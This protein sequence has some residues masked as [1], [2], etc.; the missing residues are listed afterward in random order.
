[1]VY[2][3][4]VA[5]VAAIVLAY[6]L[7]TQNK[8]SAKQA[9][10]QQR[11][12]DDYQQRVNEQQKLLEDYRALEK[13]FDNVGEGYEQALLA[14][15]KMNEE[16]DKARAANEALQNTVQQLQEANNQLQQDAQKKAEAMKQVVSDLMATGDQKLAALAGK[17]SDLDEIQPNQAP[18]ERT[19]NIMV[20]QVA[21]E[22][23]RQS[24]IDKAQYIKFNQ[25][26]DPTAAATM[27]STNLQKAARSLVHVLDNALKFTTEG[28]VTLAVT[29]DMDKMQAI[30][31]VEDTGSGIEADD[32]EKV[33]EPYVKLNQ[34]F[35]GQGIGLTVAR[36]IARRLGG[37]LV[38][39]TAFAGP[40]ARFVLSLPI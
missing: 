1:M 4:V 27:M 25:T 15:D 38:L 22:A 19:D 39:D 9:E 26:V 31:T 36:N 23:V 37:D 35:D 18:F 33:F 16:Q 8:A 13:N 29:V 21:E 24:G 34:F 32:A 11:L 30:Y 5:L 28:S 2:A 17:I 10:E 12:L 40:G 3:F 6:A 7:Y 14:F 20:A